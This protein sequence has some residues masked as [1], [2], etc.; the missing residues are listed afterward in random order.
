[1]TG[2]IM[3]EYFAI[4]LKQTKNCREVIELKIYTDLTDVS[5]LTLILN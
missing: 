4:T 1:V 3:T 5:L 2:S